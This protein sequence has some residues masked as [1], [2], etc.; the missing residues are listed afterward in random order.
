ML[1]PTAIS[2]A[3]YLTITH[4]SSSYC[5]ENPQDD[6][7][8]DNYH[9]SSSKVCR[10]EALSQDNA[11]SSFPSRHDG[12]AKELVDGCKYS[13]SSLI[14]SGYQKSHDQT[15]IVNHSW[16]N[17][18][19]RCHK[20]SL[21]RLQDKAPVVAGNVGVEVVKDKRTGSIEAE[22]QSTHKVV[23]PVK[24]PPSHVKLAIRSALKLEP[25]NS[26][27][28][29]DLSSHTNSTQEATK[30]YDGHLNNLKALGQARD[31]VSVLSEIQHLDAPSSPA[32]ST[33]P[34]GPSVLGTPIDKVSSHLGIG[35]W[36]LDGIPSDAKPLFT[37]CFDAL[38]F[39]SNDKG[40]STLTQCGNQ[41]NG[42]NSRRSEY[43][44]SQDANR[45]SQNGRPGK[46]KRAF[47]GGGNGEGGNGDNDEN[48]DGEDLTQRKRDKSFPEFTKKGLLA[49]PFYKND[50]AYFAADLFHDGKY[51]ICAARGFPDI[52][53][54]K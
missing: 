12:N 31:K 36:A 43:R 25:Q 7:A 44:S 53:R 2:E 49:C 39:L 11:L 6:I 21:S 29:F 46:R 47:E 45:T 42:S 37:D 13:R 8:Q 51:F 40:E 52:A 34:P 3:G 54:L 17:T 35:S 14:A 10:E 19:Q 18:D 50:P 15:T 20:L 16:F 28:S 22:A 27:H 26:Q 5:R 4:K 41:P 48:D 32:I 1:E 9:I 24:Q 38:P 30:T 23:S 33:K